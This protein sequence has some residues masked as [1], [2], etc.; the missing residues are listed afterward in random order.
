MHLDQPSVAA[1]VAR[2]QRS[3]AIPCAPL[4][5]PVPWHLGE[6][7]WL[8]LANG[9]RREVSRSFLS[10]SIKEQVWVLHKLSSTTVT[11][12]APDGGAS[13]SLDSS[14]STAAQPA[15]H[16]H[17]NPLNFVCQSTEILDLTCY[18]NIT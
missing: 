16:S 6:A 2:Q 13:L 17:P 10:P 15:L 4:Y 8:A 3:P 5:F 18:G 9:L 14:V 12:E 7:T 1:D 11:E